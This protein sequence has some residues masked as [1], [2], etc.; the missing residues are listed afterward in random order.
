MQKTSSKR[1]KYS[2]KKKIWLLRAINIHL[3]FKVL[4]PFLKHNV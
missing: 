4:N 3:Q 2:T 1:A